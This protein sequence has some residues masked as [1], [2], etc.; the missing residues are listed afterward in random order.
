MKIRN[1]CFSRGFVSSEISLA[2]LAWQD[3]NISANKYTEAVNLNTG[4]FMLM[5]SFKWVKSL[6]YEWHHP[7]S[8]LL[9]LFTQFFK[10]FKLDSATFK[11]TH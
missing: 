9:F 11:L 4:K 7:M 5:Q 1:I 8:S 3:L 6:N 2:V 10:L